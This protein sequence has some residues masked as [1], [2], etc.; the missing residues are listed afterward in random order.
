MEIFKINLIDIRFFSPI[1]YFDFER[2]EGNDFKMNI[3]VEYDACVFSSE[4][5][6]TTISYADI[7]EIVK[8]IMQKEWLLL[9]S[10]ALAI[11]K[12]LTE[13]WPQIMKGRIEIVKITPPIEG[14]SGSCGIEYLF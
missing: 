8:D 13:R 3:S 11:K 2:K 10:V 4:D 14:I 1:G 7:Y 9:E 6:D 12:S 5:L